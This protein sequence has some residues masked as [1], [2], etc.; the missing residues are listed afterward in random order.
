MRGVCDVY[1]D[2]YIPLYVH[3]H[4]TVCSVGKQPWKGSNV[5][6]LGSLER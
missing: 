5:L 4:G 1:R 2:V 6:I 3:S